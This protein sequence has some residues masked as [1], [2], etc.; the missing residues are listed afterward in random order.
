MKLCNE[1]AV[2]V[3]LPSL[4]DWWFWKNTRLDIKSLPSLSLT[5]F[6]KPEMIAVS[7]KKLAFLRLLLIQS[8]GRGRENTSPLL[9]F[10]L[11]SN[12]T[13]GH[14][15]CPRQRLHMSVWL[16]IKALFL[17]IAEALL[18]GEI[19]VEWNCF[20]HKVEVDTVSYNVWCGI[21]YTYHS[22]QHISN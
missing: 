17:L 5:H 18:N 1:L 12:S 4:D 21:L 6:T 3:F 7:F 14:S 19:Q 13:D 9:S 2:C 10:R 11:R 22:M 15:G 16:I 20:Y 8:R